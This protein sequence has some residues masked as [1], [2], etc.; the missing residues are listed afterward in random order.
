M[1][2][3]QAIRDAEIA[4]EAG[5][6]TI[7]VEREADLIPDGVSLIRAFK[8]TDNGVGIDDENYD[9]FNTAFSDHKLNRG[10]KG[11]GRFTWLKAFDHAKVDSVFQPDDT[12]EPLRRTFVFD[13]E[14]D[15]DN[16]KL[17]EPAPG[18]SLNTTVRLDGY[19]EPF[20]SMCPRNVEQLIEKLIEHFLLILLEPNCPTVRLNDQGETYIINDIFEKTYKATAANANFKVKDQK[21]EVYGFRL[22]APRQSKHKLVYAANQRG[23]LSDNLA[24]YLPN[25]GARLSDEEENSFV[26]IAIVQGDYLTERVNPA[27]T[28]FDFGPTEDAEIDQVSLFADEEIPRNDIR[29]KCLDFIQKDLFKIIQN[30]NEIKENKIRSYVELEAPQYKILIKYMNDFIDTISPN[31][32]KSEIDAT[33]HRELHNREVSMKAE[34]S[35]IIKEAEKIDDYESYHKRFGEFMEQ[36]NELGVSAL[37][38]YVAHRKIL[39]EF[40]DRAISTDDKN[41]KYP[42]EKVVHQLVYPMQ[43]TSED[44]PYHEQNLWM[45]DERLAFHSFVASDKG[46]SSIDRLESD[47][48]KRADLVIFDEQIVFTEGEHPINSIITVEFK[49]PGRD[50]YTGNDNPVNQSFRLIEQIRSGKFKIKGRTILI[51]NEKIPAIAYS[52]C[53]I[54]PSLK[55]VL[56][57]L[58]ATETPDKQ[59][60][61]G[62]HRNHGVYYEVIGYG[63]LLA[64]A[65]K[66]NRIFFDK[67]NLIGAR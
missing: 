66:R 24:D 29:Q 33:L 7:D 34:G 2:S 6:I 67:L 18:K 4:D 31:A 39:L 42:L 60:Y 49:R 43:S 32:T 50:D 30:I 35:R 13:E 55:Q 40:L 20:R 56:K 11:L 48:K 3:F 51:S 8:I 53:D 23:V 12:E 57:D 52:I 38:Q 25:L 15:P 17:P 9:S 47:S 58:D 1:N 21:F 37:A 22:T 41:G 65:Q 27:R 46:L 63:K 54:T 44:I 62:F 5:T 64:D 14:Y 16:V 28:D 36:Y 61:Y 19:R 26:Y 59:G 10:G 45:I